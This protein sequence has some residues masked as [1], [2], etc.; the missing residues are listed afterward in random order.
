MPSSDFP[1]LSLLIF[2]PPAA[3]MLLFAPGLE[4]FT[5]H[6]AL[7][8]SV[9]ELGLSLLA[10]AG[11]DPA[12]GMQLVERHAWIGSIKVQYLLGIDGVSAGFLP[13]SSLLSA[14]VVL[15]SWR[16][17]RQS[18]RLYFALLL[19]LHGVTIGIYC[20][21]D[22]VLFFLFWEL[23]LPPLFFLIS[24][25]GIGP[26]RRHAATQYT[27]FML[28][29]GA[30]LLLGFILL[31]LNH[32]RESGRAA[33]DGLSFDYLALL[34]T[35]APPE[36]QSAVFLL[37]FL[38]FA[39]KAPVFPFHVWLPTAA[40]EGP[41]AIG[42]LLTGLKLGLYGILRFVI[43]LAPQASNRYDG[44]IAALGVTGAI[45]GALLALRQTNLRRLL[46]FASINHVGMVLIGLAA[47][48]IQGMQGALLQTLNFVLVAGGLFLLAGFLHQRLASTE[49]TSLGGLARSMPLAASL[50][51]M[52]GLA[53]MGVPGTNGFAA[54]HLIV[55]GAFRS[56]DGLG[57]AA[58]FGVILGAAYLLSFFRQAFFGAITREPVARASDLRQR[59]LWIVA[60][61]AALSLLIGLY[62]QPVLDL[63]ARPLK[64]L[65]GRLEAGAPMTLAG[66]SANSPAS[67]PS[68]KAPVTRPD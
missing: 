2:L 11:F 51:F 40:M 23:T 21:L 1:L 56:H 13:L 4:R 49:L 33:P 60:T 48:N 8:A 58:L 15:A 59:E 28:A 6:I 34:D 57:L 19:I 35:P 55:I 66:A 50:F 54:E 9:L 64:V 27:L 43:P 38:G 52:L 5:R 18:P 46:A 62:P 36:V 61:P 45:Y 7:A 12:G 17:I 3:A 30:A 37:L 65:I 20:A 41:V 53:S 42:A 32:A 47:L 10:L 26:E 14:A 16:G 63:T 39:V 29:G 68:R 24:L 31:A 44:L 67:A 22:L 25:W